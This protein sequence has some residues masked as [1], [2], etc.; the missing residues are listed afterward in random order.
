MTLEEELQKDND[1]LSA[2]NIELKLK[3]RKKMKRILYMVI[4]V[5]GIS[6]YLIGLASYQIAS[7]NWITWIPR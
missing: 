3:A 6:T 1:K 4:P 2:E 7:I 5:L